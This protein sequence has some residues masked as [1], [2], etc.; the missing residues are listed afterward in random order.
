MSEPRPICLIARRIP[1]AGGDRIAE[2]CEVREGGPAATPDL[3]REL[4]PGAAAIVTDPT[5]AVGPELLDAAGPGLKLVANFAVG[6]DNVDLDACRERGVIA[7]NTPDV[8][9]D[10]TAE[11]ALALT[12]AAA[13]G[14]PAAERRLR[15]GEWKGFDTTGDLGTGLSGATFGIVGMGRIGRRY[16]EL[17]R[18]L[19]GSILYTARNPKPEAEAALGAELAELAQLLSGADVVSV[20]AAATPETTGMIGARELESMRPGAIL[21]NT[22][23]GSLV[24]SAALAAALDAG[25]IA[26]AGLDVYENEPDVA[27]ELLAAP[28]CVLLPH[29]GS[30]TTGARDAMA[31]L[32]ADAVVAVLDGREPP[33]R[34]V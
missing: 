29:V 25:T 26:A 18:P 30:A 9:T 7:T 34:L 24:D 2:R 8:L 17:V 6:Y 20:H 16:A 5:V 32:V 4:A 12:L 28:N 10:A 1:A 15:D 31:G 11:L 19:A 27:P 33:N 14:L 23:R 22:A 13:R 3:L 21:V